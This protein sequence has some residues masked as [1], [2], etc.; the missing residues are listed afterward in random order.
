M[1]EVLNKLVKNNV[2]HEFCL[3]DKEKIYCFLANR[4]KVVFIVDINDLSQID[5]YTINLSE[6]RGEIFKKFSRD[7]DLYVNRNGEVVRNRERISMP[8]LLW[9]LYVVGLHKYD[10]QGML[11]FKIEDV[12]KV[13]RDRFI[14]R[15]I[16]IEYKDEDELIQK[17]KEEILP[18]E[19]LDDKLVTIKEPIINEN[20][21]FDGVE[22]LEIIDK[23][24]VQELTLSKDNI[25]EYLEF[26]EE[27]YI[28]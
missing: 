24:I 11:K 27:R 6:I 7:T 20:S 19:L 23:D 12:E 28:K 1:Q 22:A 15:K 14:A 25:I 18:N 4:D 17:F 21:L 3:N 9:D 16:I 10:N 8:A 2:Y 5:H 26:I 13:K